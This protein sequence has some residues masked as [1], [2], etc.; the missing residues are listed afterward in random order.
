[1]IVDGRDQMT[2]AGRFLVLDW[3][4][5]YS[6]SSIDADEKVLHRVHA[7]HKAYGRLGVDYERTVSV[8]TD[9]SWLISDNLRV[10][11]PGTSHT[12]RLHWLLPDWEWM[13]A[14][15]GRGLELQIKSPHGWVNL[16][17][18]FETVSLDPGFHITLGRAG[19]SL[20]G[21]GKV[22]PFEGWVSPTYG[23]KVPALSLALNVTTDRS[24]LF[25][26]QFTFPR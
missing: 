18:R 19:E 6:R 2:R 4:S 24:I 11:H 23:Q 7:Y 14:E 17:S 20:Q 9:E 3:A 12:F 10:K 5:A 25:L 21:S 1:V 16:L 13:M 26:S 15:R 22:L 8:M